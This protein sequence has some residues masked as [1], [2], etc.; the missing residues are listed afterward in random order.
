MLIAEVIR[1]TRM[2]TDGAMF[3]YLKSW[4]AVRSKGCRRGKVTTGEAWDWQEGSEK[5][6]SSWDL[7]HREVFFEE[8][9]QPQKLGETRK[10]ERNLIPAEI[11]NLDT[12]WL[13]KQKDR[14]LQKADL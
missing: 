2:E 9:Q 3:T 6:G 4:R 8:S 1:N 10:A 5:L 14:G 13:K 12:L 11:C 7:Q